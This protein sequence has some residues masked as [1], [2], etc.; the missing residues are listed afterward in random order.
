MS[1]QTRHKT[2]VEV[3]VAVQHPAIGVDPT[4]KTLV[5]E[6]GES[7][8]Q[9]RDILCVRNRSNRVVG[10][11]SSW[12]SASVETTEIAPT[13]PEPDAPGPIDMSEVLKCFERGGVFIVNENGEPE[14][15]R[16]TAFHTYGDGSPLGAEVFGLTL[17]ELT[18][19]VKA[20]GLY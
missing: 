18:C 20:R 13:P 4:E 15:I 2:H 16:L 14:E 12:L 6:D 8:T 17:A 10:M 1:I 7:I 5:H 11:Y 9:D 19:I 3:R